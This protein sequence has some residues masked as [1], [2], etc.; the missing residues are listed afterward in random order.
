MSDKYS[1][2]CSIL[3]LLYNKGVC[4]SNTLNSLL[5]SKLKFEDCKLVVWNNGP[6][7]IKFENYETLINMGFDISFIET[8]DNE[9]LAKVYNKFINLFIARRY[10]ILDDDSV[11]NDIYLKKALESDQQKLTIPIITNHGITQGPFVDGVV[12]TEGKFTKVKHSIVAVGSGLIIG[13]GVIDLLLNHYGSIFDDRFYL[14]GVD[15]TFFK[16]I[17]NLKLFNNIE[18]IQGF[19]HSF[20]RLEIENPDTIKFRKKERTY[21]IALTNIFYNESEVNSLFFV[22]NTIIRSFVKELIG[23]KSDVIISAFIYASLKRKHYRYSA[24]KDLKQIDYDFSH[25]P[26]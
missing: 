12:Y 7:Q 3:V 16:R 25:K 4:E 20:S 11:L 2:K 6:N 1:Y 24:D 14:Y 21:D 8:V 5:I 26:E 13:H 19:E 23:I 17:N 10:L 15:S 22:F 18:V 9:S